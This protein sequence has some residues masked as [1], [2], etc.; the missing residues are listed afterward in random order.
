MLRIRLLRMGRRH[1]PY[2]RIVVVDSRK[3][4]DSGD[5]IVVVGT[6][7]PLAEKGKKL[8]LDK[9]LYEEWIKKGAKPSEA[10]LKLVLVKAEKKK[11]WPDKKK[12]VEQQP[13]EEPKPD[14]NKSQEKTEEASKE[15]PKEE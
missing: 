10:V 1:R 4:R 6:Y 14:T 12:Q 2:Y 3:K 11:L 15:A 9:K 7:D 13:Q 8:K 5:Y